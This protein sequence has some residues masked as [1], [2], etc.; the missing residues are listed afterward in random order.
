[1][2]VRS[3][4]EQSAVLTA[5]DNNF[6]SEADQFE[7]AEIVSRISGSYQAGSSL[8]DFEMLSLD[9]QPGSSMHYVQKPFSDLLAKCVNRYEPGAIAILKGDGLLMADGLEQVAARIK[10]APEAHDDFEVLKDGLNL[11]GG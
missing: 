7:R 5:E 8:P 2:R 10:S 11:T 3:V 4:F 9:L 6:C 1:M